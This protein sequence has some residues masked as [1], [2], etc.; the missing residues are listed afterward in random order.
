MVIEREMLQ[1]KC[2]IDLG[3]VVSSAEVYVNG[4]KMG[5][6]FAKPYTIDI[7]KGLKKGKNLIEILVYSTLGNHYVTIP[8]QFKGNIVAGLN[9]E[10]E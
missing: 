5:I 3:K 6:C 10:K 8:S 4:E 7:T 1:G 9:V 2:I